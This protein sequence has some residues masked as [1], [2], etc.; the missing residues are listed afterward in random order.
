MKK[1][2][3]C[4]A[5]VCSLVFLGCGSKQDANDK[6]FGAAIA[7]YLDKKGELCLRLN[8]WPVDVSEM[9]LRMQKTLQTGTAAQ[10]EAL[11]AIGL[12]TG[13][14]AEVDQIGMFD[15]KPTGHK[16]KVKRYILT[17]AGKKFYRE[18]EVDQ[19]GLDGRKKIMQ[20]DICYG[21]KVLDKI[22]KWE[23]PMKFG[24]YQEAN[25][26]YLYKID[27]LAEWTKKAEFLSAFP[28][29]G[30]IIEA[31]GSKEQQGGVKLTSQGWEAKG[32]D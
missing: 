2:V 1:R 31:A 27:H 6:N 3:V 26:K 19:I 30:Q 9:D 17:D 16:F 15:N 14:V 21:K 8:K 5:V 29:V 25:V 7:Q 11:A 32:L 24:D 10:M 18:K 4:A 12:T 13:S 20:G 22:V 23:G 28:Y